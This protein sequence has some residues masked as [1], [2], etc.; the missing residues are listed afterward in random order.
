MQCA[1]VHCS[2][3][4]CVAVCCS[5]LQCVAVCITLSTWP[6]EIAS[7]LQC[8]PVCCSALQH[9]AVCCSVLHLIDLGHLLEICEYCSV[10]QHIT[11]CCSLLQLVAVCCSRLHLIN[12]AVRDMSAIV[13]AFGYPKVVLHHSIVHSYVTRINESCHT[14]QCV[15]SHTYE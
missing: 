2:V 7:V 12:L 4:Q 6:S 8:V 1:A 11:A 13:E 9:G 15:M 3:L 5:V 10:L 14:C